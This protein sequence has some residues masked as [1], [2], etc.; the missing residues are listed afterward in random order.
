MSLYYTPA[1]IES[2]GTRGTRTIIS[3][4][5]T[6]PACGLNVSLENE[7]YGNTLPQIW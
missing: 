6:A 5:A 7:I 4:E 1:S 2:S 3:I